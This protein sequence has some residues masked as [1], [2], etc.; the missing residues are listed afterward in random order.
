MTEQER[1]TAE[2]LCNSSD[3]IKAANSFAS[4]AHKE[5]VQ[6]NADQRAMLI[7]CVDRTI[8]E[9]V[10]SIGVAVG[11][12]DLIAAA[13]MNMQDDDAMGRILRKAHRTKDVIEDY[14]TLYQSTRSRLR[15]DYWMTALVAV[16]TLC[17][18][19][20][21]VLGIAHWITTVSCLL[22]NAYLGYMIGCDITERRRVMKRL[23]DAVH[24]EREE[25]MNML[26]QKLQ[27]FM[28]MLKSRLS[29]D[30]DDEDDD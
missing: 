26:E 25:R 10:G 20:F 28:D 7:C 14:D 29:H 22:L 2:R 30:D 27:S 19:V 17:V 5:W 15:V 11:D 9:G 8:P 13:L 3:F 12:G 6:G 23:V 18:I 21:Q 4:Y 16:W 1:Q 24:R